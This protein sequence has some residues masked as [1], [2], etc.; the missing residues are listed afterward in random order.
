MIPPLIPV[1]LADYEPVVDVFPQKF[2][3]D[4]RAQDRR[5][6]GLL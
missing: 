3:G 1:F 5:H 4:I 2:D 6:S